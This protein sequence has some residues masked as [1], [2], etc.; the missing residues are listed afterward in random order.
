MED[1]RYLDALLALTFISFDLHP[2]LP[3]QF[4]TLNHSHFPGSQNEKKICYGCYYYNN[5]NNN[6]PA[7]HQ[8]HND[9]SLHFFLSLAPSVNKKRRRFWTKFSDDRKM[10]EPVELQSEEQRLLLSDS[11]NGDRSWRLNFEGFQLSSEHTEKKAKPPRGLHDCYGVLG[12]TQQFTFTCSFHFIFKH[13]SI[14]F[15]FLY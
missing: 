10:V 3:I 8:H 13:Y 6:K 7:L 11:D 1:A 12:S 15:Y 2:S 5:N 9:Y 4:T 14:I